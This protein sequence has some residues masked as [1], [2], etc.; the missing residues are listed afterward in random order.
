MWN[1]AYLYCFNSK[2]YS[3]TALIG[4]YIPAAASLFAAF[5]TCEWRSYTY[6]IWLQPVKNLYLSNMTTTCEE[7]ILIKY[8]YNL[9]II[10]T[11]QIWL[12]PV[13]NLYLLSEL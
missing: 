7:F 8:D 4:L 3:G 11:Y 9:W 2:I 10:Y 12:Q 5:A 13:N 1:N 6:Q